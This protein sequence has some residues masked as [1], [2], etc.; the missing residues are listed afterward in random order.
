MACLCQF[1]QANQ[2]ASN[3][4]AGRRT[5]SQGDAPSTYLT[6]K[7]IERVQRAR[8]YLLQQTGPNSFLIGGD[9]PD[10]KFRVIIGP[11]VKYTSAALQQGICALPLSLSLSTP[12]GGRGCL[13]SPPCLE[14][15]GCHLIPLCYLLSCSSA[16]SWYPF[17]LI[18]F[19][20]L[21]LSSKLFLENSSIFF[22]KR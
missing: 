4:S 19:C 9:S 16:E 11:Q 3:S 17:C 12:K 14:S 20:Q 2:S 8:L 15:Q 5:P 21:A 6:Q 7:R 22:V 18:V 13:M 10:H 1:R